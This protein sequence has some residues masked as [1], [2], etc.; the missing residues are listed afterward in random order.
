MSRKV[1]VTGG[2]GFIGSHVVDELV[3]RGAEVIIIDD[4]SA[5]RLSNIRHVLDRVKLIKASILNPETYRNEFRGADL[6]I[7]E[8]ALADIAGCELNKKMAIKVNIEGTLKVL[9]TCV[10]ADV[11]KFVFISSAGVHGNNHN[12]NFILSEETAYAP[13][14]IYGMTKAAGEQL[15]KLF[16]RNYGLR[17]VILRYF[18]IYGP[19]QIPKNNSTSG[20]V[21]IFTNR[22]IRGLD[23]VVHGSGKQIRDFTYVVDTA[24]YTVEAALKIENE[25]VNIGTGIPTRIIDLAKIIKEV[26]NPK[27]KIRFGPRPKYDADG[28]YADTSKLVKL[29]G[30]KPSTKLTNGI[31]RYLR[32]VKLNYQSV[33]VGY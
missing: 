22:A 24:K 8:A 27:V 28:G 18:S 1:I 13:L 31:K 33:N 32:W 30:G 2:A 16:Q 9:E 10:W 26:V 5:G 6:V 11:E 19:R 17:N 15:T 21:A 7:H 29:L 23:I 12:S 4:F 3:R 25:T 14:S 20:A